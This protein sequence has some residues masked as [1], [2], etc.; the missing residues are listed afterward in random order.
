MISMQR[1]TFLA[2][3]NMF[4]IIFFIQPNSVQSCGKPVRFQLVI[5]MFIQ[6]PFFE[7]GL[8]LVTRF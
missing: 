7:C 8:D 3:E 2:V 4:S 6:F 1:D 5:F